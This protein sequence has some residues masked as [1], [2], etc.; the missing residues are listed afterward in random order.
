MDE[1]RPIK[2]TER[3][4]ND[5]EAIVRYLQRRNPDAAG[6]IGRG[7]FA[8]VE[9]LRDQPEIGGIIADLTE[10]GWRRLTYRRWNIIYTLRDGTIIIGRVWPAALG[11]VDLTL[12]LTPEDD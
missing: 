7:I 5:L 9:I 4:S 3:A 12:P 10:S 2:W 11:E 8:K 1:S 6:R